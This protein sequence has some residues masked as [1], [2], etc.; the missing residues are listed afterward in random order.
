[1]ETK[2]LAGERGRYRLTQPVQAI[3]V[4]PTVQAMLAARID[5]LRPRTS[6]CCR[7]PPSS[8]RTCRSRC[9]RRLRSC[10]TRRC[11]AGSTTCRRPSSSTRPGSSRTR[12]HLQARAHAR[13]HVRRASAGAPPRASCAD[14]RGDRD[15]PPGIAS[16]STS[17]GWPITPSGASFGRRRW[18]TSGRPGSKRPRARRSGRPGLLRAGARR[19]AALPDSPSTLEQAFEIRLELRPVLAQLGEIRLALERLREA[20]ALAE[21]LNDDGRRGRVCAFMTTAHN[22]L[23]ELDEALVTGARAIEIAGRLG[24]AASPCHDDLSRAGAL[25]P[26]RLRSGDRVATENL[27]A[28]PTDWTYESFGNVTPASVY[29]RCW[30]VHALARLGG[31]TEATRTKSTPSASPRRRSIANTVGMALLCARSFS[32]LQGRWVESAPTART[33]LGVFRPVRL[34]F[35]PNGHR[36]GGLGAGG[37]RRRERG[38]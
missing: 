16:V 35:C 33:G 9:S 19:L 3:Q 25:L 15:A 26:G 17:S 34:M 27:A 28:L 20:E 11:V 10:P 5:R 13:G 23:G 8:A 30:L 24:D 12:V 36:L 7:P 38:A 2:A 21:R 31:F 37:A 1:M 29:D 18:T 6:G 22:N 14:R 32:T 4:P